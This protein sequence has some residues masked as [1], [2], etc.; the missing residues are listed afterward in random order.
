M[1]K[2]NLLFI[3]ALI[4]LMPLIAM[5]ISADTYNIAIERE[6]EVVYENE[7]VT[8]FV[9]I[10]DTLRDEELTYASLTVRVNGI[11]S[12][13]ANPEEG[14]PL[15]LSTSGTTL[16]FVLGSFTAGD[17][18]GYMIILRY[19]TPSVG[20]YKS[21]WYYFTVLGGDRPLISMP[22]WQI[23]TIAFGIAAVLAIGYFVVIWYRKKR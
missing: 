6:T 13:T 11:A 12:Y 14:V 9:T 20:E 10:T 4:V 22:K 21:G 23:A 19:M 8:V 2:I 18:I 3:V 5:K 16:T 1:K 17:E 15:L 7:M